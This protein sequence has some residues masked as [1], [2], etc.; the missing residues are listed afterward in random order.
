MQI[1]QNKKGW[2]K[3][4]KIWDFKEFIAL[5]LLWIFFLLGILLSANKTGNGGYIR[6]I[7][8][9]RTKNANTARSISEVNAAREGITKQPDSVGCVLKTIRGGEKTY[10]CTSPETYRKISEYIEWKEIEQ[11]AKVNMAKTYIVTAYNSVPEQTDADFCTSADG[12]NICKLYAKGDYSCASSLPFGTK[13][14]IPGFGI[15]TVRDRLAPKY[16]NRID[17]HMGGR[18]NI[19]LAYQWGKKQLNIEIIK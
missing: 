5:A 12:S 3:E 4:K 14:R 19:A 9:Y 18:E 17:I 8:S 11:S 10:D 2:Y 15:C 13:L 6:S 16:A 1:Y 7:D